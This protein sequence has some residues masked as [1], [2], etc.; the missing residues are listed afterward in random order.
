MTSSLDYEIDL[1]C[2]FSTC[3]PDA[4][5]RAIDEQAQSIVPQ[6]LLACSACLVLTS[7]LVLWSLQVIVG[8]YWSIDWDESAWPPVLLRCIA[9]LAAKS[10]KWG[11]SRTP[12]DR[13]IGSSTKM[14]AMPSVSIPPHRNMTLSNSHSP[15]ILQ[16]LTLSL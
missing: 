4:S 11:I 8:R 6:R 7:C 5:K 14:V 2:S 1:F 15:S 16:L 12:T 3:H 10:S 13:S 9:F